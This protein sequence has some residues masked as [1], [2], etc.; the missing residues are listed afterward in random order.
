MKL[1]KENVLNAVE[2]NKAE[3]DFDGWDYDQIH[4]VNYALHDVKLD[5]EEDVQV[6]YPEHQELQDS[7]EQLDELLLEG[8]D[9]ESEE[10][11]AVYEK[12]YRYIIGEMNDIYDYDAEPK[13]L[14]DGQVQ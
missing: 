4:G 5:V 1:N 3:V 8:C 14:I 2:F 12:I 13:V 7:R 11:M 6:A 10:Y 9:H